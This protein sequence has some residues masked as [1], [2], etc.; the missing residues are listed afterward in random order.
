LERSQNLLSQN[1]AQ[2]LLGNK[3]TILTTTDGVNGRF[4]NANPAYPFV[5]V[6]L[7]YQGNDVGLGITRTWSAAKTCCRRMRRRVC[8]ATSTP[9]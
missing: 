9:S 5:K 1:E 8:W 6:A 2:S 7:D 4:E 3:Y